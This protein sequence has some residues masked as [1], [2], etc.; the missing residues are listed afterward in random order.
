MMADVDRIDIISISSQALYTNTEEI[1]KGEND[2][3]LNSECKFYCNFI[4][5]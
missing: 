5:V 3:D 2:A 4:V 1:N